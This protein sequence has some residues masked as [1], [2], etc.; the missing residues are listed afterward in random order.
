MKYE[1]KVNF[2]LEK[3]KE[4]YTAGDIVE[5]ETTKAEDIN[6]RATS[7]HP[8]LGEFLK[9]LEATIDVEKEA[10]IDVEKEVEKPDKTSKRTTKKV[11]EGA[12]E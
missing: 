1:I 10:T 6:K 12:D 4:E 9:P 3:E 2:Y 11:D 5:M 8:T 7:N